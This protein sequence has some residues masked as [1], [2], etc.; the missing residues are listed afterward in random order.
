MRDMLVCLLLGRL[1]RLR[2]D[3]ENLAPKKGSC[4]GRGEDCVC[5]CAGAGLVDR[6]HYTACVVQKT[7]DWTV[8]AVDG[9][10]GWGGKGGG[11]RRKEHSSKGYI[12]RTGE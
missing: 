12:G 7:R 6:L 4:V 11:C 8:S 5:V 10:R 2:G 9:E 1:H 3:K